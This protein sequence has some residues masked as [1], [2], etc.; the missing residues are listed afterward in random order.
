MPGGFTTLVSGRITRDVSPE[1]CAINFG[2]ISSASQPIR[3]KLKSASGTPIHVLGIES[4]LPD[5]AKA[6]IEATG[7]NSVEVNCSFEPSEDSRQTFSGYYLFRV[8]SDREQ[9]LKVLFFGEKA[10]VRK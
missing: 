3:L 9:T 8:R 1:P 6:K 7:V 10:L 2:R 4:S 5:E